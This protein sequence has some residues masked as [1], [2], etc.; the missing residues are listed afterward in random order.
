MDTLKVSL[1]STQYQ[2]KPTKDQVV[3][4]NNKICKCGTELPLDTLADY[5]GNKGCTFAPAIFNGRRKASEVKEIQLLCL[6]FDNKEK[7]IT[8]DEALNRSDRLDLPIAFAYETF[9]SKNGSKF[10]IVFRYFEPIVNQDFYK[11]LINILFELFPEADSA[12]KDWS[13]MFYGGKGLM[14]GVSNDVI[15]PEKLFSALYYYYGDNNKEK[16]QR[17]KKFAAN[18]SIAL[19]NN[20]FYVEYGSVKTLDKPILFNI[21]DEKVFAIH[22]SESNTPTNIRKRFSDT[23]IKHIPHDALYNNCFLIQE[24]KNGTRR[25]HYHEL[26]GILTN[27]VHIAGGLKYFRRIMNS[28]HYKIDYNFD[29]WDSNCTQI[30]KCPYGPKRCA[31]FCP[32]HEVCKHSKNIIT[33]VN[34]SR[35]SITVFDNIQKFVDIKKAREELY[36]NVKNAILSNNNHIN[37]IKAQT[38]IGKTETYIRCIKELGVSCIIAVPTNSLKDEI[39]KRM[40]YADIDVK[41]TPELPKLDDEDMEELN[42]LYKTGDR[43]GYRDFMY[44][45]SKKYE[46]IKEYK[47]ELKETMS[48]KGNIVTTHFRLLYQF[49]DEILNNHTIIIDEDIIQTI[50]E[51]K[52]IPLLE[53]RNLLYKPYISGEIRKRIKY[54]SKSS[55]EKEYKKHIAE[56]NI[57]IPKRL[58]KLL[59][60]DNINFN[61]SEFLN[62]KV[63]MVNND[64]I[65]YATLRELPNQKIILMSATIDSKVYAEFFKNRHI[66]EY[67]INE[68]RYKGKVIQNAGSSFSRNWIENN[69][70]DYEKIRNEYKEKG[71]YDI[72]FKRFEKYDTA[73]HFGETQGKDVYSDGDIVVLGTPFPDDMVIRLMAATMNYDTEVINNDSINI[74]EVNYDR[75]KFYFPTFKDELLKRLHIYQISSEL[76]QAVGRGRLLNNDNTVYVFS[77]FPVRQ[78]EFINKE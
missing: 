59:S 78:A 7:V 18:N 5:V 55:K 47:K 16:V 72:C 63:T 38:G 46:S 74:R 26:W 37:I 23:M 20:T 22:L 30:S 52:V 67:L 60:K 54:Y 4:I 76:E 6:D 40:K 35:N 62:S 69:K 27:V 15:Y 57:Y 56:P 51:T 12:T 75:Y 14:T 39:Y 32:H 17:I 73:L 1:D 28:L 48:Y 66:K 53:I 36:E 33:T 21:G 41:K 2:T 50:F 29:K 3:Y 64:F 45:L 19:I 24:F 31:E 9:S 34:L 42:R 43:F 13:R 68:A 70:E 11:V 61:L 8:F 58:Q 71:C 49:R 65:Y 44:E 25:L 77:S 10:R